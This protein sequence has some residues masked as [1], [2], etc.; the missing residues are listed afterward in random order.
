MT[1][2]SVN[3]NKIA[4]LKN[5]RGKNF[6]DVQAFAARCLELGAHGL[7]FQP[8]KNQKFARYSDIE[9]LAHLCKE[10]GR[11]LNVEGYPTIEFLHAVKQWQPAQ[12]TLMADVGDTPGADYGWDIGNNANMLKEVIGELK[13]A[14]I[15][16]SLYVNFDYS[17]MAEAR[18]VG[19][20]R[21]KLCTPVCSDGYDT[22]KGKEDFAALQ[23]AVE[24]AHNE[25]LGVSVGHDF[26]L[27]HLNGLL[28][29]PDIREV[30]VGPAM[31][32]E[33]IQFGID[34]VIGRYVKMVNAVKKLKAR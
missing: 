8:R 15:R 30:S 12:C 19:A 21:I 5:W 3:L 13:A 29:L 16:T 28:R 27:E 23:K 18:Q 32:L 34:K 24:Q 4:I 17:N 9:P 1:K 20:E 6:R 7:T 2:L 10:Y 11:E 22:D 31:I 14:N 33:S 25:G 26:N